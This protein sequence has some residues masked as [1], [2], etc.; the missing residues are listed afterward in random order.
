M[1]W[2]TTEDRQRNA[3]QVVIEASQPRPVGSR[4]GVLRLDAAYQTL[5]TSFWA[6]GL[7]RLESDA[8][9]YLLVRA[10]GQTTRLKG[11]PF[12]IAFGFYRMNAGGL[13]ALFVDFPELKLPSAPSAPFV[14]FETIRGLDLDDERHRIRDAINGPGLRLCFAEGEGPG[15]DL[16]SGLCAGGYVDALYDVLIDLD[17]ACRDALNDEWTSLLAYHGTLPGDRRDF[18]AGVQQMQRENP[19]TQN[20]VLGRAADGGT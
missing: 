7:F 3:R 16:G 1:A 4:F 9:P 15:E 17:P 11:Q 20:P 10:D 6:V 2:Y 5:M 19:L 18:Q 14:L 12:R 13:I 8:G